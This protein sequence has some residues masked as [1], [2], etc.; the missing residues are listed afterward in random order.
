MIGIFTRL[1]VRDGKPVYL[2]HIPRVWRL[3]QNALCHPALAG[4]RDWFDRHVP[5]ELRRRPPL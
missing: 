2:D 1:C 5:M 4:L 3:L